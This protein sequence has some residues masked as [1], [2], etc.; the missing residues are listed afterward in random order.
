M[1]SKKSGKSGV[2]SSGN[3]KIQFGNNPKKKKTAQGN[4]KNTKQ[5]TKNGTR[6]KKGR[7]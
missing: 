5:T 7:P 1:A 2:G 6:D 4:S 3:N